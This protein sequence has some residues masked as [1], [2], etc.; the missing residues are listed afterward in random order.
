MSYPFGQD[1]PETQPNA[2]L[3]ARVS[4]AEQAKSELSIQDQLQS[5][6]RYCEQH[7]IDA[8]HEFADARSGRTLDG[9]SLGEILDL[10]KAGTVTINLLIVHSFSRLGRDSFETEWLWRELE[11]LGFRSSVSRN[12]SKIHQRVACFVR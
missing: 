5:K 10:I 8:V 4:S 9:R 1:C 2:I 3:Y 7:G 6:R 12:P 11:K